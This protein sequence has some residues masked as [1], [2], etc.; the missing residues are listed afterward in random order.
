MALPSSALFHSAA[1]Q[2]HRNSIPGC[3]RLLNCPLQILVLS[4]IFQAFVPSPLSITGLPLCIYEVA[5]IVTYDGLAFVLVS[6]FQ[7]AYCHPSADH[8]VAFPSNGPSPHSSP[9]ASSPFLPPSPLPAPYPLSQGRCSPSSC[10]TLPSPSL[11][12][13]EVLPCRSCIRRHTC[14]IARY[15]CSIALKASQKEV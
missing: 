3:H 9:H 14:I 13:F 15:T 7:I 1:P 8:D 11:N 2:V 6:N 4:L 12:G 5:E 10:S